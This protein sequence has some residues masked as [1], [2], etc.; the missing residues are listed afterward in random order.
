MRK[1]KYTG[2]R[3]QRVQLLRALDCNEQSFFL[4]KEQFWLALMLKS[5]VTTSIAYNK[6]IFMN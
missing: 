5:L 2:S 6:H 3:L 4:G 1:T